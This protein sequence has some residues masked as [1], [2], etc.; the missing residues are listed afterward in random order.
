MGAHEPQVIA[1]EATLARSGGWFYG[2]GSLTVDDDELTFEGKVDGPGFQGGQ[3][4]RV[5][6]QPGR[7]IVV[8]E[9]VTHCVMVIQD[10]VWTVRV[11]LNGF[12]R[13]RA[14]VNR[15][16]GRGIDG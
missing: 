6:H 1:V 10:D 11:R 8:R 16:R 2:D 14:W 15:L 3:N 7:A 9:R 13:K 5:T 12:L 4:V